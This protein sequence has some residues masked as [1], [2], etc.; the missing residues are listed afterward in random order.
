MEGSVRNL[1]PF[2]DGSNALVARDLT[3]LGAFSGLDSAKNPLLHNNVII[4][5]CP[6]GFIF[7]ASIEPNPSLVAA[8]QFAFEITDMLR[9]ANKVREAAGFP[10]GEP[11]VD[12]V[13]YAPRHGNISN[14]QTAWPNPFVKDAS[15]EWEKELRIFWPVDPRDIPGKNGVAIVSCPEIAVLVR[16]WSA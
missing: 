9:F 13:T 15:F 16:P 10:M 3:A 14:H 5:E 2:Y 7:C 1:L 11:I 12:S 6:P 4:T 8:G